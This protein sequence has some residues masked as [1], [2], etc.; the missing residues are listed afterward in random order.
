MRAISVVSTPVHSPSAGSRVRTRSSVSITV[1][2]HGQGIA[3][4]FLPH[5]FTPF[6]QEEGGFARATSGLG[7]GLTIAKGLVELHGGSIEARSDGEGFIGFW[8]AAV[9]A[10]LAADPTLLSP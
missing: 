7:L 1:C 4:S 3:P 9:R 5:V 6:R 10:E 2:D 8:E